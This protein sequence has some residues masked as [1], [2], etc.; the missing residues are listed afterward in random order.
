ME[1]NFN[2]S[3]VLANTSSQSKKISLDKK[4]RLHEVAIQGFLF[5]CGALSIFIT[6]GIIFYIGDEAVRFFR[7]P[8]VNLNEY[9]T[10]SVWQPQIGKFGILPLVSGT[11]MTTVIAMII[12]IPTGIGV[13][14][15]LSE[16]ASP[17]ARSIIKPSLEVLAGIPTVVLGY[18]ALTW[19]TPL[20]RSTFGENTVQIYN[21]ASAGLVMGVLVLPMISSMVE[22]ALSAVPNTLRE[23]AYGLG[24]TKLEVATRI[25]FPAALSG[26][27]AALIIA[28]SRAIGEA[29]IVTIAAG[30]GPNLTANPFKGAETMTG[31]IVRIS[32]G[33]ISYESVQYKSLFSIALLLFMLTLSLNFISQKII[34]RFRESYE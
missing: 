22:D 13:A 21:T 17:R 16:Y 8:E 9:F 24:A 3:L 32:G 2:Q 34:N 26:V 19:V 29:M 31:H 1:K 27:T 20:L 18:F 28:V 5:L 15:Y 11:L 7:L 6:I 30:S 10:G 4:T 25:V 14:I 12:A 33:D 23:G